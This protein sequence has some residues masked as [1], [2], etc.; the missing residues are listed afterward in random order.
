MSSVIDAAPVAALGGRAPAAAGW[1]LAAGAATRLFWAWAL[2]MGVLLFAAVWSWRHGWWQRLVDSDPSG[3]SVGIV[4]LALVITLWC[5]ARLR[6]LVREC[7]PGSPWRSA[8][9]DGHARGAEQAAQR[10]ADL[11]HGPHETAWWFAGA[12]IKL[13]LLGTVIGFIVMIGQLDLA[14]GSDT[15]QIQ[16]LLAQM[17]LG[18]GIALVTTLVGL[19]ANLLLGVQLLLLDRAADRVVG[20]ILDAEATR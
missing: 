5:G 1:Q 18:M 8:Y 6:R 7:A 12:T 17:T 15:A 16:A 2:T 4:L 19:L 20:A 10:L 13:G 11:T 14:K 9:R 3:I